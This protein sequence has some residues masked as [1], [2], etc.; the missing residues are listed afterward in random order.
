[1][2]SLSKLS[3][4]ELNSK[5]QALVCDERRVT[6]EVLR[7][8]REVERRMLFAELGYPSLFAYAT[9][10]LG[11]S[12]AAASRRI[13]A[14]R[15]VR[16]VAELES[17]I[18]SGEMSLSVVAQARVAIRAH[19]RETKAKV[20]ADRRR[21]VML[22]MSG[23]SRREAEKTLALEL[24]SAAA[25]NSVRVTF[26]FTAE[27]MAVIEELRRFSGATQDTKNL[28]MNSARAALAKKK[29]ERGEADLLRNKKLK[30]SKDDLK[31]AGG[32]TDSDRKRNFSAGAKRAAWQKAQSRCEFVA[33]NGKRCKA[34]H[35]LEFDHRNPIAEG[36][37]SL[38]NNIRVL[39]R[40]HN[41]FEA[42]RTLGTSRMALYLPRLRE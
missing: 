30:S 26:D 35:G 31:S 38:P 33:A 7:H 42:V 19:E 13:E 22:S 11:Y 21:E 5:I 28:L 20:S 12:E 27:E 23:L 3:N 36:G 16:E 8:L 2:N 15:A 1:M 37:L 17:K 39:C 34:R 10:E 41:S 4:Q 32:V 9:V 29:R 24:P 18:E 25:T 40:Q 14:M 6:V